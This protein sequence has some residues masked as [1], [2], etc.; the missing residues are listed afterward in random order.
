MTDVMVQ[1][2]SFPHSPSPCHAKTDEQSVP[3]Q[4][5]HQGIE[6]MERGTL[7]AAKDPNNN[8]NQDNSK[9]KY[10]DTVSASKV[11]EAHAPSTDPDLQ[12]TDMG[13]SANG[14]PHSEPAASTSGTIKTYLT[15][16]KQNRDSS[17]VEYSHSKGKVLYKT[18]F[19]KWA[20]LQ[21]E[22]R[23]STKRQ[24]SAE[25]AAKCVT[26]RKRSTVASNEGEPAKPL[27]HTNPG[28]QPRKA[29]L[30]IRSPCQRQPRRQ[31]FSSIGVFHKVDIHVISKGKE[32]THTHTHTH[33][34]THNLS[35]Y[36]LIIAG[37][38]IILNYVYQFIVIFEYC[39]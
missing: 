5:T 20:S 1:K 27:S 23:P 17:S 28:T 12:N 14:R 11:R 3:E 37:S 8:P 33:S 18:V 6:R 35:R 21:Y 30:P 31:L 2:F 38:K 34:H 10:E 13:S 32:V 22:E 26:V 29:G 19:E 7:K 15:S 25:S 39:I 9:L 36:F 16:E 24:L 4:R